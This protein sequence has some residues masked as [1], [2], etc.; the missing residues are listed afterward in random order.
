MFAG[1]VDPG[2]ALAS[3]QLVPASDQGLALIQ[4]QLLEALEGLM[5]TLALHGRQLMEGMDVGAD[6]VPFGR[7][8]PLPLLDPL[9]DLLLALGR[10]SSPGIGSPQHALLPDRWHRFPAS[11]QRRQQELLPGVQRG[12][13][14]GLR[15]WRR[16]TGRW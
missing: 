11:L 10:Q 4:R 2:L 15:R 6:P 16:Q 12:P 5:Q 3:V 7:T 13:G 1:R 14:M 8:H 9:P